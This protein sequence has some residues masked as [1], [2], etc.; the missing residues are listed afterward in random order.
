LHMKHSFFQ[1]I[2]WGR[3]VQMMI[4]K[5]P[6]TVHALLHVCTTVHIQ[7]S[8]CRSYIHHQNMIHLFCAEKCPFSDMVTIIKYSNWCEFLGFVLGRHSFSELVSRFAKTKHHTLG[9]LTG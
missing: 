9:G 4:N 2:Q 7:L 6:I 5:S 3:D 1:V 8:F